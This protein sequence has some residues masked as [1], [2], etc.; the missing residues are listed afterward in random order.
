M[1]F[2]FEKAHFRPSGGEAKLYDDLFRWWRRGAMRVSSITMM[3]GFVPPPYFDYKRYS[4]GLRYE[5]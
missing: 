5:L 2:L 4:G 1:N 3:H